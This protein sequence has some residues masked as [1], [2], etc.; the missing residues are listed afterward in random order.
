MTVLLHI[1]RAV[2]TV[3]VRT[4]L[5]IALLLAT[6]SVVP[7]AAAPDAQGLD[8]QRLDARLEE[9]W[10]LDPI[11]ETDRV[12]AM[13]E[14]VRVGA[15][16]LGLV[17]EQAEALR[18]LASVEGARERNAE[19]RAL[20]ER[21][22]PLYRQ[23][24][25]ERGEARTL[26]HLGAVL[27]VLDEPK[28]LE[29]LTR[30]RDIFERLGERKD[31]ALTYHNI[32]YATGGEEK[33]A[34]MPRALEAARAGGIPWIEC[35]IR[36]SWGDSL[37]NRTNYAR[38]YE[39]L[40]AA[41]TCYE[42]TD[43]V[44]NKGRVLVSLGR[45]ERAHGQYERALEF[46]QK[47]YALQESAHDEV[48]AIQSLNAIGV[49]YGYMGRPEEALPRYQ[50]A[51]ARARKL[52]SERIIAFMTGN[53]GA[54]LM[55]LHRYGEALDLLQQALALEKSD[56][57]RMYRLSQSAESLAGLG[58]REESFASMNQAVALARTV[59][60]EHLFR[61]LYYRANLLRQ[62][63]Q[64]DA[65]DDDLREA[66]VLVEDLRA[67]TVPQDFMKRG[68]SESHQE[69][70]GA[71]I[72]L[73]AQR[74]DSRAV[75]ELAEQAR[76]RAFLD[77]LAS[78]HSTKPI[79][80]GLVAR[81]STTGSPAVP[82]TN[83]GTAAAPEAV[84]ALQSR[85]GGLGGA[86]QAVA[87]YVSQ[88]ALD[89]E[90]PRNVTAPTATEMIATAKRLHSTLLV[91][92]VAERSTV[93]GVITPDGEISSTTV[94]IESSRLS[95][96]ARSTTAMLKGG[97]SAGLMLL[98]AS[99]TKP[100]REL[101]QLLIKPVREQ[102]PAAPGSLLTI[103][104]HGPLFQVSFAALQDEQGKYLIESYR[105]HY[106]PSVGV[107][108]YTAAQH[109]RQAK[110]RAGKALLVGDPAPAVSD[111]GDDELPALPWA[112]REVTEIG[113][114]LGTRRARVVTERAATEAS[115]RK[116]I[117]E[118]DLLHFATH[119]VIRQTES[120]SSF[121]ALARPN[122]AADTEAGQQRPD[123][124]T[125]GK[126]TADEVYG[127]RLH[128]DL[129]VLSACGTA[130]GPMSGDG[131]IGFTRAFLYAG[132]PS[133]IATE[134]NVPDQ[135]GYELMRRFYRF[136]KVTND[137]SEALRGAQLSVLTA[138]RKG[139]LRVGTPGGAP[140]AKVALRE[141]PLF[142]AG[143]VLVGEP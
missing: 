58:R 111:P 120:M 99:Q 37:F 76:A 45:V 50:E 29:L 96:L 118:A 94:P 35:S 10:K 95:E 36:H 110:D 49:A 22:L 52:G 78:R 109:A 137:P 115:V 125:D 80:E 97:N 28:A 43:K 42:G 30:A 41:L 38:A 93:I 141:N 23:I 132:A 14:Q 89:L 124:L 15:E 8:A 108:T 129:V 67:K 130:L 68:F 121:L 13:F 73:R 7:G 140:G 114:L 133:V 12:G 39:V 19:A 117:E 90:S 143:F 40:T 86:D 66:L 84:G 139:T 61:E 6:I 51:L 119:G 65:A 131:V 33:D 56:E 81:A 26:R 31:L 46:Y 57:K 113:A 72:Q 5:S 85:G 16:Q 75:L 127:L 60:P 4:A 142:W 101:Y 18:G 47:A 88:A 79:V 69:V 55:N 100:W 1:T 70:F 59:G 104:P 126:L 32:V 44:A 128:A 9:A 25:D 103:V 2:R 123:P 116:E 102:L 3:R 112:R 107:L 21:A 34:L 17:R 92:W 20:L 136:R 24:G 77:L 138:L 91:Y 27:G 83:D 106:T 98:G 122:V 63:N 54:C 74:G 105:L 82:H 134:W 48:A 11:K 71:A 62:A 87:P 135:T 53:L 64:L